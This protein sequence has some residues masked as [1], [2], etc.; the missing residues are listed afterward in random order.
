MGD[1]ARLHAENP[2]GLRAAQRLFLA[3]L[4]DTSNASEGKLPDEKALVEMTHWECAE[5][6]RAL[7][8]RLFEVR[9]AI[10][11]EGGAEIVT[12]EGTEE[13]AE[14]LFRLAQS[15]CAE[16]GITAPFPRDAGEA[17]IEVLH[18]QARLRERPR[19]WSDKLNEA[20]FHSTSRR[21]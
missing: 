14:R 9:K 13:L 15:R 18:Y 12:A 1:L 5:L 10:L 4:A 3:H 6:Y 2:R 11:A 8:S 16:N 17:L 7:L 21:C 19:R 20:E